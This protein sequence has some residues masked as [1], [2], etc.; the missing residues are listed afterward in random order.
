MIRVRL[1]AGDF[2]YQLASRACVGDFKYVEERKK[3]YQAR[4]DYFTKAIDDMGMPCHKFEGAFYAW[5]DARKYGL[6]SDEF[7]A[8]LEKEENCALSSG[9]AFGTKQEGF[10]RVPMT[11]PIPVLKDIVSRVENF[12]KKL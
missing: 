4:R 1:H 5:F 11:A 3:E 2:I 7:I 8:R 9:A 12:T 10:I 6:K